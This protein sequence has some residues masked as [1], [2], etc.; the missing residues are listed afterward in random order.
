MAR[1]SKAE[2]RKQ[3]SG[4][5]KTGLEQGQTREDTSPSVE[6]AGGKDAIELLQTDHRNVEALFSQF[7]SANDENT[8]RE[9]VE[10][11][12][13]ELIVH[14]Q[15]EEQ[16]FYPACRSAGVD[17]DLLDEAQVEH[18]SAKLLIWE[19]MA[20]DINA[21]YQEA[22]VSVLSEYIKH[23]VAEEEEASEG[24]FAKAKSSQVDLKQLGQQIES[25]KQQLLAAIEDNGIAPPEPKALR[26]QQETSMEN[27]MN[28][29]QRGPDR[30]E[31]G[32]FMSD[33]DRGSSRRGGGR[34]R[35]DDEDYRGGRGRGRSGG[36]ESEGRYQASE[37]GWDEQQGGGYGGRYEEDD[38]DYRGGRGRSRGRSGWYGDSE[39]HSEASERGWE[40][41]RGGGGRGRYEDDDD[42]RRYSRS[43]RDED[44]GDDD[45]D[46][47]DGRGWHG[48]PEGHSRAGR[49]RSRSDD[50]DGRRGR[51]MSRGG[52]S[53]RHG[54]SSHRGWYGDPRGHA[55]AARR[56]WRNRD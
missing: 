54:G 2:E 38:D 13:K 29:Y 44:Y 49:S 52:Q 11:I 16:I 55:E 21:P 43:R 1:T 4:A 50:D 33:D 8:K 14:T 24:I 6:L 5:K 19:L 28:R 39:G 15:L 46:D 17:S 12:C 10:R 47:G 20:E 35:D 41:R 34:Y 7:E 53:G 22:K 23:H 32:R 9:L 18:D 51:S 45:E 30:D 27:S 37:R 26:C 25:R 48:D 56:G 40:E 36:Y 31:R 3:G 42:D